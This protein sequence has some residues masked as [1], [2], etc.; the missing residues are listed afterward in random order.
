MHE[1]M[2]HFGIL[3]YFAIGFILYL[4]MMK[5]DKS[6]PIIDNGFAFTVF[7]PLYMI[8]LLVGWICLGGSKLTAKIP[9]RQEKFKRPVDETFNPFDGS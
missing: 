2:M 7:W 3:G 9:V 1:K 4:I 5:I 6:H 8:I